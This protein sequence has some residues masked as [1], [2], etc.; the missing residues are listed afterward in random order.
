M[1]RASSIL[2]VL[3]VLVYGLMPSPA[4]AAASTE[5]DY[6]FYNGSACVTV[7]GNGWEY[8]SRVD[9]SRFSYTASNWICDRKAK[10]VIDQ[11]SGADF[12]YYSP[13]KSG[14]VWPVQ[15]FYL[16]AYRSF[17]DYSRVK[18]YWKDTMT[19]GAYRWIETYQV[20]ISYECA[21][22]ANCD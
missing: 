16:P 4:I 14:C 1:R 13:F 3:V 12:F 10:V 2:I 21:W 17:D 9:V 5:C 15:K 6:F 18:G 20:L 11:P 19:G 7:N 8:V 22:Q